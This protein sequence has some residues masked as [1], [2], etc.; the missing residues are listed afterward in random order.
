MKAW[1]LYL[2]FKTCGKD[3]GLEDDVRLKMIALGVLMPLLILTDTNH[4]SWIMVETVG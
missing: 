4:R 1:R 2:S 3:G